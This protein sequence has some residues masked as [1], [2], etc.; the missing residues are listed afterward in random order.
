VARR[1]RAH[2]R[3]VLWT[4]RVLALAL[5]ALQLHG[6][7]A[8]Q[9]RLVQ[10]DQLGSDPSNYYAA[11]LRL[12]AGHSLY[13]PLLPG[14]LPVPGYPGTF[15]APLLSPPLVAVIWRALA[16]LPGDVAMTGW[17]AGGLILVTLILLMFVIC[18]TRESLLVLNGV[19]LLHVPI[20]LYVH[21]RNLTDVLMGWSAP[22]PIAALSGNLN[23]YLLGLL[24]LSSWLVGRT[25]GRGSGIAIAIA[26]ALKLGPALLFG[27]LVGQR[28]R[29]AA[30]AFCVGLVA[31]AIVG[32]VGAG[33]TANADYIRLALGGGVAPTPLSLPGLLHHFLHIS[34]ATG[35]HALLLV[36]PLGLFLGWSLRRR[37]RLALAVGLG[38]AIFSSPVVMTGNFVLLMAAASPWPQTS[39]GGTEPPASPTP[40]NATL[41]SSS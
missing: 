5:F 19:L 6:T 8:Q 18:G 23:T 30:L 31:A 1:I 14:D 15:P 2:P 39:N 34:E 41:A 21:P 40:S 13:G 7:V 29:S 12:N 28:G 36:P 32:L 10:P 20:S 37:P 17:W 35:A 27:W 26:T 4:L 11:G 38:A 25:G 16:L 33:I 9:P 22:V 3:L 24:V